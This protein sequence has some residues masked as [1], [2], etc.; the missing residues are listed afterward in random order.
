[1]RVKS[2]GDIIVCLQPTSPIRPKN[3]VDKMLELFHHKILAASGRNMHIHEWGKYNNLA[4]QKIKVG[5]GM[6]V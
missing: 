2:G 3:F 1:M 6:M 4:R 5:S